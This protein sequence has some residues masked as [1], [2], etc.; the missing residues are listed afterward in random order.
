MHIGT[1]HTQPANLKTGESLTG[2]ASIEALARVQFLIERG[3]T[4]GI[5]VGPA[6]CG[7]SSLFRQVDDELQ[8]TPLRHLLLNLQCLDRE[9]LLWSLAAALG[10]APN[11]NSSKLVVWNL[12]ND[13]FD[14]TGCLRVR[15]VVLIDHADQAE[16]GVLELLDSLIE[17][18]VSAGKYVTW[19]LAAK[20]PYGS[21]ALQ[22]LASRHAELK[23]ELTRLSPE[24]SAHLLQ[25]VGT[26]GDQPLQFQ[27]DALVAA[28]TLTAGEP[29]LLNRLRRLTELATRVEG[30]PVMNQDML[31]AALS[32][33][34]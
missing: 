13:Y 34:K 28:H 11:E 3:Q 10:L 26:P 5:V 4:C 18:G 6:G 2:A 14:G 16:P 9:Q 15:T 22:R 7:S 29:R 30:T 19:I 32:E 17:R 23:I 24:E 20:L 12:L 31:Q 33:L 8:R 25:R 21:V 27:H 1:N